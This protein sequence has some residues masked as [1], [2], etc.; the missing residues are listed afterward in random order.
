VALNWLA[1]SKP[2]DEPC[3]L[4]VGSGYLVPKEEGTA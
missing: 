4:G 1:H 2:R 3:G